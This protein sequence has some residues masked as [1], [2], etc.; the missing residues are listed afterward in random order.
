MLGLVKHFY[1]AILG[2][3]MFELKYCSIVY[4]NIARKFA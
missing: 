3:I 2:W 4:Y 1:L